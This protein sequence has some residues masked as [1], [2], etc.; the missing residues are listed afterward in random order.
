MLE[1]GWK[2]KVVICRYDLEMRL[3]Q[4]TSS[5][6]IFCVIINKKNYGKP[7][8]RRGSAYFVADQFVS[9]QTVCIDKEFAVAF[10]GCAVIESKK[11]DRKLMSILTN[12]TKLSHAANN[13]KLDAKY[14]THCFVPCLSQ[15]DF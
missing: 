1:T 6:S 11:N 7:K 12:V 13:V 14:S 10:S 15:R 4:R 8:V 2:G 5:Q 3:E 9:K